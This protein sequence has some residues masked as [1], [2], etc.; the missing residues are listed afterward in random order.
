M[1]SLIR[2]ASEPFRL[3]QAIALEAMAD[4]KL[5]VRRLPNYIPLTL[6]LPHAKRIRVQGQDQS[7]LQN[8]QI[9]YGLRGQLIG[10]FQPGIDEII[11]II[12]TSSQLLAIVGHEKAKGFHI[13]RVFKYETQAK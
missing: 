8:G 12:D 6:A 10:L 2:T 9:S 1:S 3:D 5:G 13:R 4:N 11:Q 7:L